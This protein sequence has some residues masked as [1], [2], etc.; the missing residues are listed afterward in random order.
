VDLVVLMP[1]HLHTMMSFNPVP[2]MRKT[3]S[4]WKQLAAR[5]WRIKWQRDFFDH[6]LRNDREYSEKFA[7]VSENPVRAGLVAQAKDW[8]HRWARLGGDVAI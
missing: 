1:D 5:R 8:P 3:V 6:R 2:G 7:Y 4:A